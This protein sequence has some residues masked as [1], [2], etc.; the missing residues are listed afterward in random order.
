M[1]RLP[2]GG[3]SEAAAEASYDSEPESADGFSRVVRFQGSEVRDILHKTF[4]CGEDE[5]LDSF[6]RVE[7][8]QERFGDL[9]QSDFQERFGGFEV[10]ADQSVRKS[11]FEF[12]Q[13]VRRFGFFGNAEGGVQ[14]SFRTG[15]FFGRGFRRFRIFSEVPA[16]FGP[17]VRTG[18]GIPAFHVLSFLTLS[19]VERFRTVPDVGSVG[20]QEPPGQR[21]NIPCPDVLGWRVFRP[22]VWT[23]AVSECFRHGMEIR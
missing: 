6:E 23:E 2:D 12:S 22:F 1:G 8:L 13:G 4:S 5:F 17:N 11:E 3:L 15:Q 16:G 21:V 20:K 18:C 9:V 19:R 10:I 14:L 7:Y